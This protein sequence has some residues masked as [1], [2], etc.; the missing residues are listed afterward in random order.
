VKACGKAKEGGHV[1]PDP[2]AIAIVL[3]TV[4]T[5]FALAA[6]LHWVLMPTLRDARKFADQEGIRKVKTQPSEYRGLGHTRVGQH[7][8][9]GKPHPIKKVDNDSRSSVR[10]SYLGREPRSPAEVFRDPPNFSETQTSAPKG[11]AR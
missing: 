8:L 4:L 1:H 2:I 7:V 10:V 11:N 6:A 3:R 5:L 9:V